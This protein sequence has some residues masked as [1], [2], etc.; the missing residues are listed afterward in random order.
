MYE[1]IDKSKDPGL[2]PRIPVNLVNTDYGVKECW[3]IYDNLIGTEWDT[4]EEVQSKGSAALTYEIEN[5]VMEN[6]FKPYENWLQIALSI[7][8]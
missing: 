1:T 5:H 7:I 6:A 4:V 3:S 8:Q 2:N